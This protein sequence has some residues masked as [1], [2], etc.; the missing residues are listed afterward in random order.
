MSTTHN[1]PGTDGQGEDPPTDR[2]PQETP[3]EPINVEKFTSV[4]VTIALATLA[5]VVS[6]W[7]I[8]EWHT[9]GCLLAGAACVPLGAWLTRN[10]THKG[11]WAGLAGGLAIAGIICGAIFGWSQMFLWFAGFGAGFGSYF[12]YVKGKGSQPA[13]SNDDSD[14]DPASQRWAR[15]GRPRRPARRRRSTTP[16]RSSSS[17]NGW[18]KFAA[19]A[20]GAA[21]VAILVGLIVGLLMQRSYISDL[22]AGNRTLQQ[23]I[24]DL[25]KK[26]DD[27]K[28]QPAPG[29]PGPTVVPVNNPQVLNRGE[30][31]VL[32][33]YV[34]KGGNAND[35]RFGDKIDVQ[36]AASIEPGGGTYGTG[37]YSAREIASFLNEN[38]PQA[39]AALK[40]YMDRTGASREDMINPANW[41]AV[42]Y[43]VPIQWNDNMYYMN[44]Q[45][46]SNGASTVDPAGS[47]G[48][49]Y[50]GPQTVAK[51]NAEGKLP[52]ADDLVGGR[53]RCNGNPQGKMA[54]PAGNGQVTVIPPT[55][56]PVSP[57]PPHGNGCDQPNG[58]K[59]VEDC[60]TNPQKPECKPKEDCSTNPN[61]PE[62][63][64]VDECK[65][66]D[67]R[68]KCKPPVEDCKTNPNQ[69]KCKPVETCKEHPE[70]PECKPTETCADHPNTPECKPIE[71]CTTNPEKPGCKPDTCET[72]PNKP[73]C[74]HKP[75]KCQGVS[76]DGI[77]GTPNTG[78]EQQDPQDNDPVL[79]APTEGYTPGDA[80]EVLGNQDHCVAVSDCG[81]DPADHGTIVDGSEDGG[82]APGGGVTFPIPG[83]DGSGDNNPGADGTPHSENPDLGTS[84]DAGSD[85]AQNEGSNTGGDTGVTGNPLAGLTLPGIMSGNDS[86]AAPQAA[87]VAPSG[88]TG[89]ADDSSSTV[90][91]APMGD[92]GAALSAF[93]GGANDNPAPAVSSPSNTDLGNTVTSLLGGSGGNHNTVTAPTHTGGSDG[94]SLG[95]LASA[96]GS[97]ANTSGNLGL[98]NPGNATLSTSG[99]FQSVT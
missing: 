70:K 77:C 28:V 75:E 17:G 41:S 79:V 22:E 88:D 69:E 84:N 52:N 19:V 59:P 56:P 86:D 98:S 14:S 54:T 15:R 6:V 55:T 43:M 73:G 82:F 68:P 94:A 51:L 62:C 40:T 65:P 38:T 11:V 8:S 63:K 45:T 67:T 31:I 13:A 30:Q 18:K 53:G 74:E 76:L 27:A 46:V 72:N 80:E 32:D 58:C 97:S 93:T 2:I 83:A 61:R 47:V 91:P 34:Q 3:R 95:D 49:Y 90:Q 7:T 36:L 44:G 37:L 96:F 57:P 16:S 10:I 9:F 85:A 20:G 4:L 48:V 24:I 99:A 64:P 39:N 5:L 29:Q 21:V 50:T 89:M 42:Q 33:A 60:K 81:M 12:A 35:L 25:N 87:L 23:Q 1:P 26:V 78:G 71:D 92:L 66:G